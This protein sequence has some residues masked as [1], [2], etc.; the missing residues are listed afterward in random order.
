MHII[1]NCAQL[2][3]P[4]LPF[5]SD[6]VKEM[7][8]LAPFTWK[9]IEKTVYQTFQV[10]PLFERIDLNQIEVEL[11]KLKLNAIETKV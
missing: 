6:K 8:H 4:F 9:P 7:L 11:E 3:S 1:A 2:L 10:R 5:S